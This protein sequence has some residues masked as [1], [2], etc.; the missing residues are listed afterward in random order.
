MVLTAR[1]WRPVN[2]ISDGFILVSDVDGYMDASSL[3]VENMH[4]VPIQAT[5]KPYT[6]PAGPPLYGLC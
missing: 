4:N 1:G 6:N 3:S 5:M 2:A